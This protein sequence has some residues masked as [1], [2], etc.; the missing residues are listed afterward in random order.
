MMCN[1]RHDQTCGRLSI[2]NCTGR[3]QTSASSHLVCELQEVVMMILQGP[4]QVQLVAVHVIAD[5]TG[6]IRNIQQITNE[7]CW[8]GYSHDTMYATWGKE[9][10]HCCPLGHLP[11][12]STILLSHY[13]LV[14]IWWCQLCKTTQLC[15]PLGALPMPHFAPSYGCNYQGQRSSRFHPVVSKNA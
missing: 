6:P 5:P 4:R 7:C 11:W 3:D 1:M 14:N 15:K 13:I 9:Y 10:P 8:I 12:K 2:L